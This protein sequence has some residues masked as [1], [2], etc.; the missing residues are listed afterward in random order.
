MKR[1]QQWNFFLTKAKGE[2]RKGREQKN[3]SGKFDPPHVDEGIPGGYEWQAHREKDEGETE[4]EGEARGPDCRIELVTAHL[5]QLTSTKCFQSERETIT[6]DN[7]F[8]PNNRP[9]LS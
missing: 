8:P 1:E 3:R 7:R 2:I 9:N 5:F 4:I 6:K